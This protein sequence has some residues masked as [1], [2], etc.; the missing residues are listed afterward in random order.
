VNKLPKNV[1]TMIGPKT[2]HKN[3]NRAFMLPGKKYEKKYKPHD[4]KVAVIGAN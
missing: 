1:K 2:G 3:C 4:M